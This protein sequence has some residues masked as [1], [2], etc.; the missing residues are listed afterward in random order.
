MLL[1][2]KIVLTCISLLL[3]QQAVAQPLLTIGKQKISKLSF[4]QAYEKTKTATKDTL[5]MQGYLPL[6]IRYHQKLKAAYE[7]KI[8]TLPQIIEEI[9]NFRALLAETY[10]LSEKTAQSLTEE[11]W[12]RSLEEISLTHVFIS[13]GNDS[14][15]AKNKIQEAWEKLNNGADFDEIVL[16]YSTDETVK[17]KRGA[18]GYITAFSLPYTIESA[19]YALTPGKQSSPIKGAKGYHILR[20]IDRRKSLG[21]FQGA[22]LLIS[23]SPNATRD[24]IEKRKALADSLY[25]L[26]KKGADFFTLAQQYSDDKLTAAQGGVLPDFNFSTYDQNFTRAAFAIKENGAISTPV[27]T[28]FGYHIILRKNIIPPTNSLEDAAT[29]SYFRAMVEKDDRIKIAEDVAKKEMLLTIRLRNLIKNEAKLWERTDE[30]R[31]STNELKKLSKLKEQKLFQ[32]DGKMIRMADWLAFLKT[33]QYILEQNNSNYPV[34][35]QAFKD[36]MIKELYK[37]KLEK[38]QPAFAQQMTEF[39]EASLIFEIMEQALW[40]KTASDTTALLNHYEVNRNKYLWQPGLS[41]IIVTC[42]DQQTAAQLA[43]K[44]A[45]TPARW[46]WHLAI[47]EGMAVAD[48]SRFEFTQLPLQPNVV[49]KENAILPLLPQEGDRSVRFIYVNKMHRIPT[50][51]SFEEAIG[52]VITDY[53]QVLEAKWE[54]ELDKTFPAILNKAEWKKI[55]PIQ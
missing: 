5:S 43:E 47:Y 54:N 38:H 52:M 24:V 30:L 31:N 44:I 34:L 40:R 16:A 33:P 6:F 35:L 13:F 14:M 27:F 37:A 9:N 23:F 4:L 15:Q 3:M 32:I 8:D 20:C 17:Q 29:A 12:Q 42:N 10:L 45:A 11:A 55:Q 19:A 26:L 7:K 18:L 53:Q 51:R 46:Q 22:H 50:Q 1:K 28:D 2:I 41:G 21:T 25:V 49:I 39:K 48:S 36:E